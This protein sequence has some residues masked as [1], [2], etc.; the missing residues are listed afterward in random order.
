MEILN[1]LG[2]IAGVITTIFLTS[3]GSERVTETLKIVLEAIAVTVTKI[4]KI[5]KLVTHPLF[6]LALSAVVAWGV[7]AGI[8]LDTFLGIHLF[9]DVDPVLVSIVSAFI[10]WVTSTFIHPVLKSSIFVRQTGGQSHYVSSM[11]MAE[12]MPARA[13]VIASSDS[14]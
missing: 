3:L 6:K 7:S 14:G 8:P 1:M 4:P 10:V 2:L 13:V 5:S 11:P 9:A 12:N